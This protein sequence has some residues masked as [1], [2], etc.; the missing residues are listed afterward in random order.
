MMKRAITLLRG[1]MKA[2]DLY[3]YDVVGALPVA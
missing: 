1:I 3:Q 2:H